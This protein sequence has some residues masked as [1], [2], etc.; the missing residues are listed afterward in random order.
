M[1]PTIRRYDVPMLK[2]S[3]A[4][5]NRPNQSVGKMAKKIPITPQVVATVPAPVQAIFRARRYCLAP[6]LVPTIATMDVPNPK[7]NGIRMYSSRAPSA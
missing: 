2:M 4:S 3:S 1:G 6:Q 5:L 7:A